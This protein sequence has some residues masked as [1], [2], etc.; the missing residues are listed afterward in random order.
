MSKVSPNEIAN[1][2]LVTFNNI[3]SYS[4]I[5]VPLL[6]LDKYFSKRRYRFELSELDTPS[7][8]SIEETPMQGICQAEET[9]IYHF[10]NFAEFTTLEKDMTSA[11]KV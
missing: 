4:Q 5:I 2:A 10:Q 3:S 8:D 7:V 11:L 9:V 1:L 6:A